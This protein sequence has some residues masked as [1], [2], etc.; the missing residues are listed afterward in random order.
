V[1]NREKLLPPEFISADGF[2]IT[3]AARRYLAPF[4]DGL[5]RLCEAAE[6][7]DAKEAGEEVRRIERAARGGPLYTR[8]RTSDNVIEMSSQKRK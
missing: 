8:K 3:T 4:K 1:A 7:G 5:P 2:G 6:R